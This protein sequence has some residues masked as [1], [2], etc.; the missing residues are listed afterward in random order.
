[1][2]EENHCKYCYATIPNGCYCCE[3][4]FDEFENN[5]YDQETEYEDWDD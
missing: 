1:M 2:K 4:C 3:S 5:D